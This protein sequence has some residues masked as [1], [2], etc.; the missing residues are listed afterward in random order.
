LLQQV[1]QYAKR[2]N[3]I[4]LI[5]IKCFTDRIVPHKELVEK[6]L[7]KTDTTTNHHHQPL[8]HGAQRHDHFNCCSSTVAN[9]TPFTAVV[10]NRG[11]AATW[12]AIYNTQGCREL[13]RFLI[14]Y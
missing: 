12:G 6:N 14:Y 8:Q 5:T 7:L 9:S 1:T 2:F 10:P 11:S 3:A 13:M 4:N